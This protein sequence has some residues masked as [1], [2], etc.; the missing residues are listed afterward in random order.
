MILSYGGYSF[1]DNEV[2][3]SWNKVLVLGK[4][5]RA[6]HYQHQCRVRGSKLAANAS[7]LTAA[8]SNMEAAVSQHGQDLVFK[9]NASQNTVH[10]VTS[11]NTM[12]GVRAIEGVSYTAGRPGVWGAETEYADKRSYE[13]VFQWET[14]SAESNIVFYSETI[15]ISGGG[16]RFVIQEALTGLPQ[17]Q[18]TA[19][20]S[21]TVAIQQGIAIGMTSTPAFPAKQYSTGILM[22]ERSFEEIETPLN[23]R[24]NTPTHYPI[25][26]KYHFESPFALA[27]NTPANP[28]F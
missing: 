8:L 26:W 10:A 23:Y 20:F 6:T 4:T 24:S 7:A 25:R 28:T 21:K 16:P 18:Q 1:D 2:E 5:G 12:N 13:I 14:L 17:L 11:A 15:R 22:E 27:L 3:P 19:Q 9:D